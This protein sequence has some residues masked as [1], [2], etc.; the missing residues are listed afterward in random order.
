[1]KARLFSILVLTIAASVAETAHA[2]DFKLRQ[3]DGAVQ[4]YRLEVPSAVPLEEL[5]AAPP[6]R[7]DQMSAGAAQV[8][9]VGWAGGLSKSKGAAYPSS[10]TDVGGE[11]PG[12]FYHAS[13]IKVDSVQHQSAPVGHYIIK[14][15]GKIGQVRQTFYAAVLD[16]GRI[17]K[18][19][20]VPR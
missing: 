14:M 11:Q 5:S 4:Y 19:V 9:A 8:A 20:T 13:Y 15:N 12:G 10:T 7:L 16:D 6:A 2:I 1:M 17:V 3:A 18:P